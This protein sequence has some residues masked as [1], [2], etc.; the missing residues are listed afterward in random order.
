MIARPIT[1][2]ALQ[3]YNGTVFMYGQTTSGKTYTML[4]TPE[5]PGILPCAVRDIFSAIKKDSDHDYK[6]WISYLEIYN[7]SIN[8]LLVP[9]NQNLKIKDDPKNSGI[10]VNGLKKQ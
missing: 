1:R 10:V 9:G 8:D 5:T 4:G 7:E 2:A 3:G 6:V